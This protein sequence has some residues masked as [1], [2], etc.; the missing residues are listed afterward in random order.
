MKYI[1]PVIWMPIDSAPKTGDPV[2]LW[3]DEWVDE[4]YNPTGVMDGYWDEHFDD[5]PGGTW[6][7]AGW[8]SCHDVYGSYAAVPTHWA[9]KVK[10]K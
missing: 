8:S 7:V 10:P 6:V 3:N 9:P 2:W 4:D 5:I 1:V